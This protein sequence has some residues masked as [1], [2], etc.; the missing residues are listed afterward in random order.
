MTAGQRPA[1][2]YATVTFMIFDNQSNAAVES[3]CNRS[4]VTTALVCP[5]G[6]SRC[7]T[8]GR[9]NQKLNTSP[10]R[11]AQR[12]STTA[13]ATMTIR[14]ARALTVCNGNDRVDGPRWRLHARAPCCEN[15]TSK[16]WPDFMPVTARWALPSPAELATNGDSSGT[17]RQISSLDCNGAGTGALKN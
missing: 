3:K 13:T 5:G 9:H 11:A 4:V 12:R 16:T 6:L 2:W 7:S 1:L 15:N 14:D 10:R 17:R 8:C